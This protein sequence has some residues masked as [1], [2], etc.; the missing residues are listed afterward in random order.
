MV[1]V[2]LRRNSDDMATPV[3]AMDGQSRELK[4]AAYLVTAGTARIQN[5]GGRIQLEVL[6]SLKL[7]WRRTFISQANA[8]LLTHQHGLVGQLQRTLSA[9]WSLPDEWRPWT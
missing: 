3:I 5:A 2:G 7:R 4:D 8:Q 6:G 1:A 9:F